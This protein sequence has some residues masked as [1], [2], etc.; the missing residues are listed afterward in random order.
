MEVSRG[1]AYGLGLS[2]FAIALGI[3]LFSPPVEVDVYVP[4]AHSNASK[5]EFVV[6][7]ERAKV[8]MG[9]PVGGA[10]FLA[11]VFAMV[12][13]KT[14]EQGLSG[15]DFQQDVLDQMGMWD[16]LFWVFSAAVHGVVVLIVC[17]PVDAFGAL[18]A[19]AFTTYFLFRACAPK[20]QAVNLTQENL[21]LLGYG[22]G[23]LQIAYQVTDAR[24]NGVSV[25]AL[26]VVLD[27][28]LGIGH[29][30]DRQATIDTVSHC[31]IFYICAGAIGCSVLYATNVYVS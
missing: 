22:L 18:S 17:S 6:A 11:A 8:H 25:V 30:Y 31:R 28:F 24:A 14:Q 27:Y 19:T 23:V 16:M 15:Q 21:N 26:L 3:V 2:Q 10:A 9:M 29:T 13:C 5:G 4:R 20:S 12:T 7:V 1:A